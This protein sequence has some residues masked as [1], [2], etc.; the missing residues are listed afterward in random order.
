[1][2][3]FVF[4]LVTHV[5]AGSFFG[6]PNATLRGKKFSTQ[7]TPNARKKC[8]RISEGQHALNVNGENYSRYWYKNAMRPIANKREVKKVAWIV[9]LERS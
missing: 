3:N 2:S 7:K 9:R 4:G 1:M 6:L 5:L 8:C